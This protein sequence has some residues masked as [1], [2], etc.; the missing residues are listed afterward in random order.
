MT[1]FSF[2][3]EK[4]RFNFFSNWTVCIGFK[5]NITVDQGKAISTHFYPDSCSAPVFGALLQKTEDFK[6]R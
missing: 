4:N 1:E 6:L 2:F 5:Q 3:G